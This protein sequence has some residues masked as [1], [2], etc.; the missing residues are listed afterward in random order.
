MVF[1][2]WLIC[3]LAILGGLSL[4]PWLLPDPKQA[5]GFISWDLLDHAAAYGGLSV[6]LML[7][8]R[9][10]NRPM[11]MTIGVVLVSGLTG[12]LFEYC[13]YWFTSTRHFSFSDAAANVCG[14]MLGVTAFW[15]VRIY[16][17]RFL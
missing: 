2:G 7:A 8:I 3:Y 9:Q 14:A 13:Q 12:V 10:Q 5:I 4:N 15:A 6:L 1:K 16:R 11:A 17:M